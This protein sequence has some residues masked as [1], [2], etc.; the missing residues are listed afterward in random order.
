VN[1]GLRG[2]LVLTNP[3][4]YCWAGFCLSINLC[5]GLAWILIISVTK[6]VLTSDRLLVQRA[7]QARARASQGRAEATYGPQGSA[8]MSFEHAPQVSRAARSWLCSSLCRV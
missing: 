1:C 8:A 2:V 6:R 7:S 5:S 3:A 4:R